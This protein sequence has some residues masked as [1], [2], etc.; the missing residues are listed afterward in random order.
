MIINLDIYIISGGILRIDWFLDA[1][2]GMFIHFGLYSIL[3]RGEWVMFHERIPKSEYRKLM[4]KFDPRED[5]VEEWC[6]LAKMAGMKYVV[7]TT[8]HHDGF[9]LFDTKVSDFNSV[10]SKAG[11]DIIAEYVKACRKYGLKIGFYYS[12]LDWRWPAY[13]KGPKDRAEWDKFLEYVHT[14][15]IELMENYGEINILWYDGGWPYSAE[16][17]RSKELN[18]EVRRLQPNILINNRSGLPED[19]DTPEQYVP[20]K[21]SERPWETCM[22]INDSWGYSRG[23]NRYK[24]VKRLITTLVEVVGKGGNFLLNIGPKADGSVPYPL[25]ERLYAI[26]RWLKA[27]GESIYGTRPRSLNGG[28]HLGYITQKDTTIYMHVFRW[29][30]KEITFAGVDGKLIDAYFLA[31]RESIKFEY[32]ENKIFLKNLPEEPLDP[33]DTVIVLR[34]EEPPK[35]VELDPFNSILR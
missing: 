2:F 17:W 3:G 10:N 16:D 14:Q 30:G 29:P 27:N 21:T 9:S 31:T 7:L 8:R 1:R 6:Y 22:T 11:R 35:R 28:W 4:D 32:K 18:E 5:A 25:T 12:L 20:S 13:W 24:S 15:V 26:G 19:F 34:F 33:Y 23:D